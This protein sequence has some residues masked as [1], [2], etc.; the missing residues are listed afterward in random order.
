MFS[1]FFDIQYAQL[2]EYNFSHI[3]DKPFESIFGFIQVLPGAFSGYRWDALKY[4]KEESI[5]E[6]YL[7]TVT[8]ANYKI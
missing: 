7:K 8:D 4:S 2:F 6:D 3:M 1:V 5:L